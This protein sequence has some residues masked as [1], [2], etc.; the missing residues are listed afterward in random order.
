MVSNTGWT[1]ANLGLIPASFFAV[2]FWESLFLSQSL[3]FLVCK[4][5]IRS[6]ACRIIERRDCGEKI[7][8]LVLHSTGQW[9]LRVRRKLLVPLGEEQNIWRGRRYAGNMRKQLFSNQTE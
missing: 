2:W 6:P 5:M 7:K 4:K 8:Q 9:Y 3:C 1:Q